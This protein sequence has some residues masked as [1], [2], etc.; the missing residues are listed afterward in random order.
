MNV[1]ELNEDQRRVRMNVRNAMM[2]ATMDE[3]RKELQISLDRNDTLRAR[4]VQEL[5]DEAKDG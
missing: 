3:L 2:I 1:G 4:F 5:I